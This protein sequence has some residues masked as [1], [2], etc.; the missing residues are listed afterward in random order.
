MGTSSDHRDH[1]NR[2][3]PGA[4]GHDHGIAGANERSL[5]IVLGL[6]TL[7]MFAE[8]I[9]G[10]LTKSLALISDAA[11]MFTDAAALAIALAAIKIGQRAADH[12]RTFGYYRFEILAAAF[13][14]TVLFVVAGYIL[15]EAYQRFRNPPD[16]QS[17][18]ML[19]IA[20]IG[21]AV[22]LIGMRVLQHGSDRSLN[23]KGAYLEVWSDM[24]GSL[25]VIF[26]AIVIYFTQWAWVD[27]AV[28]AGIGLWVLP[29]TWKLLKESLNIL[30]E[31]VPMDVELD[32]IEQ[33]LLAVAGVREIHDL[34]VWALTGGK[35]SLTVH[36]VLEAGGDEQKV[37]GA[38][39]E[40]L[41]AR[42][43][44]NHTTLQIEAAA[45]DL[46]DAHG[47]SHF[48]GDTHHH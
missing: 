31:G 47:G 6:T 21:L 3:S 2:G 33:A 32:R 29:R 26:A 11:H 15:Y 43:S 40:M 16:I 8:V 41:A 24:L 36:L 27:A 35:N 19:V 22:N 44:I 42:F 10:I 45:C 18:G 37:L 13:N 17:L 14:A 20:V 25:G 39:T 5:W 48:A 38:A 9:G 46:K 7:F 12:K 30:L 4:H 23:V 1:E 34:H 28:A